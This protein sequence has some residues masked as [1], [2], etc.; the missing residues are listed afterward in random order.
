MKRLVSLVCVL[1]GAAACGDNLTNGGGDDDTD[2]VQ[3]DAPNPDASPDAAID[4]MPPPPYSAT[5]SITETA[6]LNPGTANTVMGQ[7]I[8]ILPTYSE[9][10]T[11]V[12]PVFDQM[13]GTPF[14]CKVFEYDTP[15]EV[16]TVIG[17]NEGAVQVTIDNPPIAN[18]PAPG[19][20]DPPFP[21]C[22]FQAGAGYLCPDLGSSQALTVTNSV[23]LTMLSAQASMLTVVAG[24]ATFDLVD[25]G[26]YV[27]FS[28]TGIPSL[29]ASVAAFPIVA[30][31]TACMAVI[32][33]NCTAS[34]AVIGLGLTATVPV[35]AGMLST[36]AGA[37][38][39]PGR[40]DPGHL[41]NAATVSITAVGNAAGGGNHIGNWTMTTGAG[42]DFTVTDAIANLMRNI[43][44]DGSAFTIEC[45]A[46]GTPS[47]CGSS[48]G[49]VLNI[50][51]TNGS[52]TGITSPFA[53]PPPDGTNPK[54][55]NI[56]CA[57]IGP[58]SITVPAQASAYLM[59]S[60]A[61]RIQTT[62]IRANLGTATPA[63]PAILPIAGHALVGFT[64]PTA[65]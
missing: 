11:A 40:I 19:A 60:G 44:L 33:A 8:V 50:V 37:G 1:G 10:A 65:N 30:T 57:A 12:P 13:P 46:T 24:S 6:I 7:G 42:D 36:L 64:T 18:P 14:G 48:V 55:V 27:K 58:T 22:V 9:T 21:P 39:L 2:A 15:A 25:I 63:N 43:P 47:N 17:V 38:P 32:G 56:R 5:V 28:G 52:L 61:T 54:R 45:D 59:T 35:T 4:A 41:D 23:N 51:T 20:E 31:G 62:L 53:M 3:I 34:Q 49:T 16:A 29:D 26:R